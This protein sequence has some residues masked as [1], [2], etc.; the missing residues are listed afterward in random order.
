M[1]SE[2]RVSATPDYRVLF[3]SAPGLY[4]VLDLQFRVIAVTDAYLEAT[5]TQRQ[6][7]VG[8][9]LFDVFPNP[10]ADSNGGGVSNLRTSLTAALET[11]RAQVMAVQKFD[12]PRPESEG[13]GF[14]EHFWSPVNTPVIGPNNQVEC[15]IHRLEEVT[16]FVRL[17]QR[18]REENAAL[19]QLYAQIAR[20]TTQTADVNLPPEE[21]APEEMLARIS[22]LIATRNQ[23][24]DQ[25]R[26]SQK[27]EAI[28]RLAGGVAHDFNNLLTVILG[29]SGLLKSSLPTGEAQ[30]NVQHIEQAASRATA[31]TTQ[32]LA[33]S[34]K[35]VLQPRVLNL[36]T[37]VSGMQEFIQ[38]LIGEDVTLEV[39][40][41]SRLPE[42]KADPGQIEQVIMNLAVNAR[43]AMPSGGRLR[44]ATKGVALADTDAGF[45]T[46]QPGFY[47][48]L[49]VSDTGQGMDAQTRARILEPFFTTKEKGKGTG[50]GLSTV[51]GA[52]EQSGGTI[53]V[54][55]E[56]GK[57]A[58][59]TILLPASRE[60][61]SLKAA[62]PAKSRVT[63]RT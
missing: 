56:P 16:E 21:I 33:F 62:P 25:L 54:A 42:V 63:A 15:I 41:D 18:E 26:Q 34:R 31:M 20:M 14:E 35:Q 2:T 4:V 39:E 12:L 49:T 36:N 9:S 37:V 58:A 59:F 45:M 27:M 8:R 57:G 13:G 10:P 43:D 6:E 38:R 1:Q 44:I 60:T 51:F 32:L 22:N 5:R 7:L 11:G 47:A 50:L 19:R 40:L 30:D 3:E 24:E 23:L 48:V 46:V 28:G 52:V 55:S 61:Y 29:Y 17:K 53:S